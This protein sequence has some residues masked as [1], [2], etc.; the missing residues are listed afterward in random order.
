MKILITLIILLLPVNL[1]A[2]VCNECVK[3]TIQIDEKVIGIDTLD[4]VK[5]KYTITNC[6]KNKIRIDKS[7]IPEYEDD[8]SNI[9]FRVFHWEPD[10]KEYYIKRHDIG[11][12]GISDDV[13]LKP[14]DSF[15]YNFDL[16][17]FY[18]LEHTGSYRI[19][20][21]Y[22]ISLSN[23]SNPNCTGY[24]MQQSNDLNITIRK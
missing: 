16:F 14:G 23:E 7:A 12:L 10:Y 6:S 9:Y 24:Y 20:G 5:I 3:L 22:K 4:K 2:Q 17:K 18:T 21:F 11:L 13:A 8:F 1:L 19:K 15:T